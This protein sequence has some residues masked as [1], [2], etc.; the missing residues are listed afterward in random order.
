MPAR[1][2]E[3]RT[4]PDSRTVERLPEVL[5][6]NREPT[7]LLVGDALASLA[8][9]SVKCT[10]GETITARCEYGTCRVLK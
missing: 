7:A 6:C 8:I 2:P 4:G 9:Y 10:T 5:A 1:P 3:P